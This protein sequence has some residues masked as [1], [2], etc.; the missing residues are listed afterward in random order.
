MKTDAVQLSREYFDIAN[1]VAVEFDMLQKEEIVCWDNLPNDLKDILVE[2]AQ[3][4][5]NWLNELQ[6]EK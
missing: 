1:Q 6:N 3:R 4:L 5:L 2:S